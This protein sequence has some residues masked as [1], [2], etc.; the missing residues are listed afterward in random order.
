MKKPLGEIQRNDCDKPKAAFYAAM[1][2]VDQTDEKGAEIFNLGYGCI[3]KHDDLIQQK[4][5]R[6]PPK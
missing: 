4:E 6:S 1:K 2:G 3:R 5:K